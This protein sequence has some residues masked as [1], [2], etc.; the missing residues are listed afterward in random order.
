MAKRDY[1]EVLGVSK[2]ASPEEIKK[3]YRKLALKY[4]PD[5][6]PDDKETEEKFKEAAEAYDVLSSPEKKQRYDQFGHAGMGGA[7]NFGGA[8]MSM[9]DIFSQFGDLFGGGGG[10]FGGFG[11]GQQRQQVNRGSN[12]RLKVELTLEEIA[13]GVEK[14]LKVKKYTACNS[15]HGNGEKNGNSHTTCSECNGTGQVTRIQNTLLGR[16]QTTSSC[17][18]CNGQGKVIKERCPDCNGEGIVRGEEVISVKIPAGV[19]EGLQLSVSGKGNAARRGGINGDLLVLIK[20][21]EHPDLMRD[22]NDLLYNLFISI[23]DAILGASAEIP[24][25]DGK[26]KVSIEKGTQSGKILRLRKKGLPNIEGYGVGDLLIKVNV[27]IPKDISSEEEKIMEK[28]EKSP[29]FDTAHVEREKGFFQ[30]VKSFFS[31]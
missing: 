11:G 6:N 1:Y 24:T 25:L 28:L 26:V 2:S 8:G 5:K 31:E 18:V 22:G 12:L 27:F 4:H 17:P 9:E 23:P 30:K 20:E 10:F 15:C 21:K 29:N 19:Y 7:G 14:K 13:K 3:A 16:M